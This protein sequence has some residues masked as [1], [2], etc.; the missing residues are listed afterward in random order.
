MRLAQDLV[1]GIDLWIN[2]PRRPWEACG[3]SGMKILANGGLNFSELD[4]WWAEAYDSGVGWAIGD[5][6]EHGEDLAWDATEAQEMYSILEN[7]IIPMFYERSGGKTP[8]RWIA[9]VRE[10]M[11][12]LTPEFSASRT[13]RDYTVS[14]YL[15]A[16]LSYKSRSEDGQR[17][18]QS[19]VAWKMDI[20]K[21]WES[22]RFG[23]TTTEH[24]SGQR[25]FRIE[26]FVGSLSPDSIRVELYADAHDQ[27][28]GALHPMDRC[29]DC[30]SSV[31]SLVYLST[32]S[33]TRPVTDY[34]AR[35]VPFHPGAVLPLEAPQFL[36]Q[37]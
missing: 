12:R 13:I 8:S 1:A 16:A 31:G 28:V 9:R 19:I 5:R 22:L 29:G 27:T 23:R 2:T 32:I 4:G 34:T 17:L 7:E 20:E 18:A 37:R 11:A 26:V 35:I 14:Y 25:S 6:R 33:A 21:H 3:T 30:E 10:S 24:H 15:P 36:W